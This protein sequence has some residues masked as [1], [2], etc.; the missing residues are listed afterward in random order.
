MQILSCHFI[1]YLIMLHKTIDYWVSIVDIVIVILHVI[2][3]ID[4]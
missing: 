4:V 1:F 2:V 3:P